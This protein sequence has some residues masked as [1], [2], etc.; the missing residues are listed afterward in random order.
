MATN[1]T[2]API[3][4]PMAEGLRP[5][6]QSKNT[7][8]IIAVAEA[9]L[10]FKKAFTA[11]ELAANEDPALNPNQPSQS[12]AAPNRTNGTFAGFP[13]ALRRPRNMAP[14]KAATPEEACTTI[15]PAKSN[16]PICRRNPSGCHVQCARGQ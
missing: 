6:K 13:D 11:I 16:T 14:A 15:P 5:N 12:M 3:A 9:V 1:P 4:A 2:T 10:V 8:V 7:H